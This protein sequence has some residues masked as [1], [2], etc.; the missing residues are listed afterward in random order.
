M[1][2]AR[3]DILTYFTTMKRIAASQ[4][5]PLEA[6]RM[7]YNL[8]Q[9]KPAMLKMQQGGK[10]YRPLL[11]AILTMDPE[12]KMPTGKA[13]QQQLGISATVYRRWL[14]ALYADFLAL[15]AKDADVLQFT[16]VEHVLYV[17][18]QGEVS[19]VRCR[20]AVTPRVG[21][22][23][24]LPFLS[25]FASTGTFYVYSIEHECSQGK[26]VIHLSLQPGYYNAYLSHLQRRA[27]FEGKWPREAWGMSDYK[28]KELLE[29]LYPDG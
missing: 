2:N 17:P 8:A 27:E 21:E 16:D 25:A 7:L 29:E 11:G 1:A 4:K 5:E 10:A 6:S 26:N 12:G 9:V 13:I 18:G 14:D 28:Q 15:V 19:E 23:V 20:L 24:A 22:G 3:P